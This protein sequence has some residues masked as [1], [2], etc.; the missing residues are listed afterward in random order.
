MN[1]FTIYFTELTVL[2]ISGEKK[3]FLPRVLYGFRNIA[4]KELKNL[5][6]YALKNG[7]EFHITDDMAGCYKVLYGSKPVNDK[8]T[9]NLITMNK[10][11]KNKKPIKFKAPD[12]NEE[13][14]IIEKIV[15]PVEEG[16]ILDIGDEG[17]E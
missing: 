5:R 11:K 16:G 13:D 8:T 7:L 17:N 1:N 4:D 15:P 14:E 9:T 6:K 2:E 10:G 3:T 12:K